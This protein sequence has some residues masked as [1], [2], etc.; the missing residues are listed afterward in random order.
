MTH[1]QFVLQGKE[2]LTPLYGEREAEALV[3]TLLQEVEGLGL[4]DYIMFPNKDLTHTV[5]LIEYLYRLTEGEPLQYIL[6]YARFCGYKFGVTEDT[7]IPRPETEYLVNLICRRHSTSF[8]GESKSRSCHPLRILDLCTGSGCIAWS[9]ASLIPNSKVW[10]CDISAAALAVACGQEREEFVG[11]GQ[12]TPD[13]FKADLLSNEALEIIEKETG[14]QRRE[15]NCGDDLRMDIIVSNPPYLLEEEKA[16]MQ[17]NVL[18]HEPH[19]AL[20]VDN[21][22]PL[23]FYDKIVTLGRCLLKIGGELW[24]EINERFA[25]EVVSL[26]NSHGFT[27]CGAMEDLNGKKRFVQGTW[28]QGL[29]FINKGGH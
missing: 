16:F 8:N 9:L 20:F 15:S 17:R 26:M 5:L 12:N 13:F 4:Y 18:E 10:G 29:S 23:L 19:I 24:F 7:L 27:R 3:R 2:Q 1:K 14:M 11:K 21:N 28:Q 22:T 6:G 25:D